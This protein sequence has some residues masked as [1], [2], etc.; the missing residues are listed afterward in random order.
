MKSLNRR[1][2]Q[3]EENTPTHE[4]PVFIGNGMQRW[5]KDQKE[6]MIKKHPHIKIFWMPLSPNLPYGAERL[7]ASQ[8]ALLN[9]MRSF[10]TYDDELQKQ[11]DFAIRKRVNKEPSVLFVSSV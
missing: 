11:L 8:L 5:A 1:V 6:M 2:D 7:P 9:D 10:V 4:E 3:L